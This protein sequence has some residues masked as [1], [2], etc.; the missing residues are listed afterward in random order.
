MVH[1]KKL[2]KKIKSTFKCKGT[3]TAKKKKNNNNNNENAHSW[4][5]H[6]CQFQNPLQGYS[7]RKQCGTGIWT[8]ISGAEMRVQKTLT[9]IV[10][11]SS[12]G[13]QDNSTNGAGKH[14][15]IQM[16]KNETAPLSNTIY[17]N[18]HKMNQ[19]LKFKV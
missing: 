1:I 2:L 14:L 3:R 15:D 7:N 5:T 17:R 4:R 9:F 8:E 12:T 18:S 19:R 16:Q 10:N 11:W 13:H 6:T